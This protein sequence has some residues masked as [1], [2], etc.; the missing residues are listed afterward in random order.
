[1]VVEV[2]CRYHRSIS[3]PDRVA[4]GIRIARIGSSSVRY[5]IGIFRND[6]EEASAEG[7]FVHVFVDRATQRPVPVPQASRDILR[8]ITI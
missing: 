7:H 6:E 4:V 1:V 2:Q 8:L 3:F 5:E